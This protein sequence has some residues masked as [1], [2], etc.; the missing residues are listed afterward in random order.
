[1][2]HELIDAGIDET[3]ELDF[4]HGLEPLRRHADAKAADQELGE[5]RVDHPL[6]AE[7]LLQSHGGA[8]NAAVDADVLAQH[9]HVGI[10]LH[11]AGQRQ[12]D[13]FDQRELRHPSLR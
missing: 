1:M 9:H 4:A 10:L 8:E 5:R 6:G 3:H 13:R 12:I 7:P 2:V 11:G